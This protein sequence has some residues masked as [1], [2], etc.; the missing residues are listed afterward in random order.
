M[1]LGELAG[2]AVRRSNQVYFEQVSQRETIVCGYAYT[3][4][5]WPELEDCNF[6][7]E[8][9]LEGAPRAAYDTVERYFAERAL[10]CWR[11]I[12]AAIQEPG[13][14]A[15]L[16]APLGFRAEASLPYVLAR[17]AVARSPAGLRILGARAMRR[18]YTELIGLR[19][20]EQAGGADAPRARDL[21]DMHLERLNDPQYD[22]FVARLDDHPVGV[23]SL[24]QVGEI[25]RVCDLFVHR[26]QRRRGIGSALIQYAVATARR[27]SLCPICAEA[28]AGDAACRGLLERAGFEAGRAIAVFCRS[29]ATE[30]TT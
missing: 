30:V 24:L 2:S 12:P 3:S 15:A 7:G 28:P 21:T 14:V 5:R 20:R 17:N 29:G 18:A 8:V 1:S 10:T 6:V 26:E 13:A 27:W 22:A 25:G 4:A 19:S 9:L 23:V 11:W 16:L